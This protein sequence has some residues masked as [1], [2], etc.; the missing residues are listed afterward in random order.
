[1]VRRRS[2]R[3]AALPA[4]IVCV[5]A[6][7]TPSRWSVRWKRWRAAAAPRPQSGLPRAELCGRVRR[8]GLSRPGGLHPGLGFDTVHE[9]AFGADLV[10]NEYREMLEECDDQ[11]YISSACPAIVGYVERYHP[12]LMNGCADCLADGGLARYL[13]IRWGHEMAMVFIGPCVAKKTEAE[14]EPLRGE[15]D[16]AL[17][18]RELRQMFARAG[19]TSQGIERAN[20]TLPTPASGHS[21]RSAVVRCRL[22]GCVTIC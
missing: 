7:N 14:D 18:F 2:F 12:E 16:A 13:R 17:T 20:L 22:P 11:Q 10:A 15:I 8:Y 4:A 19:V 21:T 3:N 1:M 5:F 6:A 9:V